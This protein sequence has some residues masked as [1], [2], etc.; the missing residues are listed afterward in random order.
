VPWVTPDWNLELG[1][2]LGGG[3]WM[4]NVFLLSVNCPVE[5]F[6]YSRVSLSAFDGDAQGAIAHLEAHDPGIPNEQI[7]LTAA[8]DH[9]RCI[10]SL[11]RQMGQ[12]EVGDA[13]NPLQS[14]TL[15]FIRQVRSQPGGFSIAGS[16]I[17]GIFK[18]SDGSDLRRQTD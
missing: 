1:C 9:G 12:Q 18:G 3:W 14:G 16:V 15:Q 2:S 5:D 11:R 8:S 6:H 7:T 17:F 10:T 4:L 13:R